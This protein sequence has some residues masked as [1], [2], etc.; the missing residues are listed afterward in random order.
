[1]AVAITQSHGTIVEIGDGVTP[2]EGF[3]A[4]DGVHNG[5]QGMDLNPE[6]IS[7][8]HHGSDST[9]RKPTVLADTTLTFDIYYDSADTNHAAL[10]DAAQDMTRHNFK[11]KLTDTGAEIYSFAAYVSFRLNAPTDGFNVASIEL[12]VDGDVTIE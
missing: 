12:R 3:T 9:L 5:P 2:T 4:I 8:R 6:M 11:L 7:A 10:R 1:M